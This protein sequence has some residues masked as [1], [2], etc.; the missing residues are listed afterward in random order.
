MARL[1]IS[2]GTFN[3]LRR[4]ALQSVGRTLWEHRQPVTSAR[5]SPLRSAELAG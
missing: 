2:E 4:R 5:E 3:R 1:Y